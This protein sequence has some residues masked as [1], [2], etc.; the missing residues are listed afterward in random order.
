MFAIVLIV[1]ANQYKYINWYEVI[2]SLHIKRAGYCPALPYKYLSPQIFS[3][4]FSYRRL[5]FPGRFPGCIHT[6]GNLL[7]GRFV[8]LYGNSRLGSFF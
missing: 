3:L 7:P 5:V 8:L 2:P 6:G 1:K 4:A